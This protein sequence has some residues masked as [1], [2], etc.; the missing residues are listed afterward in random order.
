MAIR[1]IVDKRLIRGLAL[2]IAIVLP[3]RVV[4][5]GVVPILGVPGHAH[6]HHQEPGTLVHA[7]A[8]AGKDR[9]APS[10]HAVAGALEHLRACVAQAAQA[11]APDGGILENGCPHLSMAIVS[12]PLLP[13]AGEKGRWRSCWAC[14]TH[15]VSVIL[16]VPSP[17]P[18]A[19]A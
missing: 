11:D 3:L 18:T 16:D 17:P 8:A 10:A 9:A 6:Q 1:F 19:R 15:Y 13:L 14:A 5:A 4:A 7:A 12:A 2:L